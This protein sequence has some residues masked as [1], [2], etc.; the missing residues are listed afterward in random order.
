MHSFRFT[1]LR[2]ALF[3]FLL[4]SS[5]SILYTTAQNTRSARELSD[6][7][8]E[9][10]ALTL[11]STVEAELRSGDQL[12]TQHVRRIF[13]DRVV[14]YALVSDKKGGIQF[15]TNPGLIETQLK[16]EK[17]DQ[18]L[19]SGKAYGRRIT[20][21]TGLPAFEFNYPLHLPDGRSELLRIVLHTYPADQI[22]S[23]A[24][25]MWWTVGLVLLIL[26]AIGILFD[27]MFAR[28]LRL[29]KKLQRSE[30]LAL[31][32]QM[33][34]V[35]A[36][37]IRNALGSIKGYTQWIN[38]KMES[39]DPIKTGLSF[40]LKGIERIESLVRD[41]LIFSREETYRLEPLAVDPIIQE[42]INS[43]IF[44]GEKKIETT[45]E[46][47]IQV[48]ADKEKVHRILLNGI[49]NALQVMEGGRDLQIKADSKG[50]WVEIRIEDSG[51]GIPE[52]EC[53]R[54]FTP[55]HTTKTTGTGLGLA[56]SKKV[57]E[58]MGGEI[59]L[60]NHPE[61]TGAVLKIKLPKT[62]RS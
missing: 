27:R 36:H 50:K 58:G 8:M 44:Q 14:A 13:S 39:S 7:A 47:G 46:P 33:T 26:W 1:V 60:F 25:R 48:F 22:V 41:L 38:E 24:Q 40:V 20:L 57:I 53:S 52:E 5:A 3:L 30:Q 11:A 2:V 10:T 31:I 61:H 9:G 32:G 55:F 12:A 59:S 34:A 37:E 51:P 21:R 4:L 56:Y 16:E 35:L 19:Q 6:Q 29:Q 15:H 23:K 42:V 45:I 28:Q 54:L 62:A 49:Q 18:W 43:E 17:L